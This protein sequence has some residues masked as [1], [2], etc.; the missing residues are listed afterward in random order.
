MVAKIAVCL[1]SA[2][3]VGGGAAE[4][5]VDEVGPC[6]SLGGVGDGSLLVAELLEAVA[7]GLKIPPGMFRLMHIS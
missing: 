7:V 2:L 6:W 3:N 1:T 4:L 5:G